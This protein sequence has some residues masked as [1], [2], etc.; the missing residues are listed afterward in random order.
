MNRHLIQHTIVLYERF[1]VRSI[2]RTKKGSFPFK[3]NGTEIGG[4]GSI[5]LL[6]PGRDRFLKLTWRLRCLSRGS[7]EP[8]TSSAE[9]L[10]IGVCV[11]WW[12]IMDSMDVYSFLLVNIESNKYHG[13][14]FV[15]VTFLDATGITLVEG[16]CEVIY[17]QL[18]IQ[19]NKKLNTKC[20][21]KWNAK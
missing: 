12:S 3:V 16:I 18:V 7:G 9:I 17:L 14:T 5:V 10:N 4:G 20:K 21:G 6:L 13:S 1:Y 8:T 2:R 15:C 11:F 19:D